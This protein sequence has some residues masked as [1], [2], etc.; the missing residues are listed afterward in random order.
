MKYTQK[1]KGNRERTA[2]D[3]ARLPHKRAASARGL[4]N[5]GHHA[6]GLRVGLNP[7]ATSVRAQR[8]AGWE[9]TEKKVRTRKG[10]EDR[11]NA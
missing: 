1:Q 4:R 10:D 7:H 9:T 2:A 11:L 3:G 8:R 6:G 5:V